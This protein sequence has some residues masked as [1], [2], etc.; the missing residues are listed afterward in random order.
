MRLIDVHKGTCS[1][2]AAEHL[3]SRGKL[4]VRAVVSASQ[5]G[6]ELPRGA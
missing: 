5:L 2:D 1:S 4:G 6:P 3:P